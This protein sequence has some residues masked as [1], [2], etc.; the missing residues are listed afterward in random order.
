MKGLTFSEKRGCVHVNCV[1]GAEATAAWVHTSPPS[2]A[3]GLRPGMQPV[4]WLVKQRSPM[5][6]TVLSTPGTVTAW[7]RP[8][9][10]S[11]VGDWSTGEVDSVSEKESQDSNPEPGLPPHTVLAALGSDSACIPGQLLSRRS[12]TCVMARWIGVLW[13]HSGMSGH[14]GLLDPF[15]LLVD[16][17]SGQLSPVT[18]PLHSSPGL[19]PNPTTT[20]VIRFYYLF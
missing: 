16:S 8:C 3:V 10:P 6:S 17:L 19:G 1:P 2:R 4:L 9:C 20:C 14:K 15:L 5:R 13:V 18:V 12:Y 7:R 11:F